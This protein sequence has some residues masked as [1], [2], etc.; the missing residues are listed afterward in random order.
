MR[1][2]FS[3]LLLG[4]FTNIQVPVVSNYSDFIMGIEKSEPTALRM[5]SNDVRYGTPL[6][7]DVYQEILPISE[8]HVLL[9]KE[10]FETRPN[11]SIMENEGAKGESYVCLCNKKDLV[12]ILQ[13]WKDNQH[14]NTDYAKFDCKYR[15]FFAKEEMFQG[16]SFWKSIDLKATLNKIN[17]ETDDVLLSE[18]VKMAV[19]KNRQNLSKKILKISYDIPVDNV[20]KEVESESFLLSVMGDE[21]TNLLKNTDI[22]GW[23][24][25]FPEWREY[26]QLNAGFWGEPKPK[27]SIN[28]NNY[29]KSFSISSDQSSSI[30]QVE[31]QTTFL[32]KT[33]EKITKSL[34]N[35][36]IKKNGRFVQGDAYLD[37]G[38]YINYSIDGL[39]DENQSVVVAMQTSIPTHTVIAY[40]AKSG[41]ELGRS[42]TMPI[43]LNLPISTSEI[44]LSVTYTKL[45]KVKIT[46]SVSK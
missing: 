12:T 43:E 18:N 45:K 38:E 30:L 17:L 44:N 13:R 46:Y 24:S 15:S 4:Y 16:E 41:L 39:S 35:I 26:K 22:L 28:N 34:K 11:S 31:G 37:Y 8:T 25:L 29:S 2:V 6:R 33:D 23:K 19:Y 7:S 32:V 20:I 27:K 40:D 10:V 21:E 1:L 5:H 42:D 3:F 36:T 9:V 14:S